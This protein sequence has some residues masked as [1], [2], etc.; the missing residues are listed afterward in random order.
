MAK[1]ITVSDSGEEVVTEVPDSSVEGPTTHFALVHDPSVL[2]NVPLEV[3]VIALDEFNVTAVL[4]NGKVHFDSSDRAAKLPTD[5]GLTRGVGVFT[6]TFE[7]EGSQVLSVTD[8]VD[9]SI[10]GNSNVTVENDAPVYVTGLT[11]ED[12]KV[13]DS[14]GVRRLR[15]S[16]IYQGT[17][18]SENAIIPGIYYE[19]DPFLFGLAE[20]LVNNAYAEWVV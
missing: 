4:Y 16:R 12:V 11:P 7:S 10:N 9:G 6:V 5:T 1:K 2:H 17:K 20:Y 13:K 8:T 15:V 19:D 18:T 14:E 3:S